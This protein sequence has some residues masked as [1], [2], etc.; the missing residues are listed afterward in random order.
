[1]PDT[2]APDAHDPRGPFLAELRCLLDDPRFHSAAL[3]GALDFGEA[4]AHA[5]WENAK[6]RPPVERLLLSLQAAAEA[7]EGLAIQL[8][9]EGP[10]EAG[11]TP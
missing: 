1:M 10:D 3:V 4:A 7:L 9:E 2:P 5:A 11:A 6:D 8:S